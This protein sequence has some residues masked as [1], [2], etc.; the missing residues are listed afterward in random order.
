MSPSE[1]VDEA[2]RRVCEQHPYTNPR[3]I[4]HAIANAVQI[5]LCRSALS[6]NDV[7]TEDDIKSCFEHPFCQC[8][9]CQLARMTPEENAPDE[10]D[11]S[12]ERSH[13]AANLNGDA[14]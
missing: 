1:L 8:P 13:S 9:D 4:S 10:P 14:L 6:A 7:P 11:L 12:Y 5:Y 2:T 3:Y